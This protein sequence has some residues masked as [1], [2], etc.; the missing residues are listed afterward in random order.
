MRPGSG[1]PNW[2]CVT[3]KGA[4]RLCYDWDLEAV[5]PVQVGRTGYDTVH[6]T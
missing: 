5:G 6:C 3:L 1:K 4:V 2:S